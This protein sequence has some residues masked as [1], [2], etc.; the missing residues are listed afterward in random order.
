MID[1][2]QFIMTSVHWQLSLGLHRCISMIDISQGRLFV[3]SSKY[4]L[5]HQHLDCFAYSAFIMLNHFSAELF[6]QLCRYLKNR[7]SNK[8]PRFKLMIDRFFCYFEEFRGDLACL[9]SSLMCLQSW[10]FCT[11]FFSISML[12]LG[13]L[14]S[15]FGSFQSVNRAPFTWRPSDLGFT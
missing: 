12:S 15:S 2:L 4:F 8:H 14:S 10:S 5:L 3:S 11:I 9:C 13:D 1:L 6:Q 7:Q